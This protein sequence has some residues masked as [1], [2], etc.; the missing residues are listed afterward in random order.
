V[1]RTAGAANVGLSVGRIAR[2]GLALLAA[3]GLSAPQV[4]AHD[5]YLYQFQRHYK[6]SKTGA[7]R[8]QVCH[9]DAGAGAFWNDYG[10]DLL[11]AGASNTN[12][13]VPYLTAVE[14]KDSDGDGTSNSVEIEKGTQPGWC[15]PAKPSCKSLYK[16]PAVP[17][18][19]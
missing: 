12:D 10:S 9:T 16:P 15:D 4:L 11:G 6:N 5:T 18:D 3:A 2:A 13:I 14:S 1:R 17:L 7:A 19:P 8:C